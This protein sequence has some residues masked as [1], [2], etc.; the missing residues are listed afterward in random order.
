MTLLSGLSSVNT[1]G[2]SSLL[3]EPTQVL[4]SPQKNWPLHINHNGWPS[5]NQD[6]IQIQE[7]QNQLN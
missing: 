5:L 1:S 2:F 3:R 4:V 7:L 6:Q